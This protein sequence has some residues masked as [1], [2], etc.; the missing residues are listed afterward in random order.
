MRGASICLRLNARSWR[1]SDEARSEA[2]AISWAGPRRCGSVARDHHEEIIEIVGDASGE[3]SDGFHFLRLAELL[4]ERAT[5]GDVFGEEF[6][7]DSFLAAVRHRTA[8]DADHGGA[9][10]AL[11]LRGKS[12][13]GS[14][15][16]EAI[17]EIEPLFGVGVEGI[18]LPADD[19]ARRGE[20]QQFQEGGVGI[21][22]LA[23]GIAAADPVG[24]IGNQGAEIEFGAAKILLRGAQS[25][26]EPADQHGH[27]EEK[28]QTKDG[29][30][31]LVGRM[32]P[33]Q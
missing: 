24:S 3:A 33:D 14:G 5:L 20:T 10:F 27:K 8:G 18:D 4:F 19:F 1:V 12:L 17:G 2:L 32:G 13:K 26:V 9:S 31:E 21:E 29:S 15:G 16:A 22:N 23:S 28:R 30:A 7:D 6:E 11:P 25:G